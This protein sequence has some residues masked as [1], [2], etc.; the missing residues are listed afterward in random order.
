MISL[1]ENL[2]EETSG[3]YLAPLDK[4]DARRMREIITVLQSPFVLHLWDFLDNA[5]DETTRWLIENASSVFCLN[6]AILRDVTSI[7]REASILTFRRTAA[8]VVAQRSDDTTVSVA[9]LG[10]IGSYLGG[11]T[12]LIAA[13]EHLRMVGQN[14]NVVFV[15]TSQKMLKRNGISARDSISATGFIPSAEQRD[16]VLSRCAVGFV[17]GPLASPESDPR[18]KYSIPSRILDFMAIGLP[19]VGTV[20]P[21]SATFSFCQDLG[22]DE[23]LVRNEPDQVAQALEALV[24]LREWERSSRK[25]LAAF[26]KL[27]AAYDIAELRSMLV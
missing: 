27:M 24:D 19:I 7:R 12:C 8:K 13:I 9:I 5:N 1:L 25:S 22:L 11:V 23:W 6:S 2:R 10:D 26:S 3:V 14:H 15:G 16:R 4:S 20:H 18:S 17:P 21:D